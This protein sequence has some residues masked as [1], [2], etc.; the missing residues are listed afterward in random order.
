M[1]FTDTKQFT[2]ANTD[3]IEYRFMNLYICIVNLI[4]N[5]ESK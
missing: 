2:S 3:L 4:K 5:I 1:K